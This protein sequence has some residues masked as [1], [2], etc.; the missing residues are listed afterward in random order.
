MAQSIYITSTE[1]LSGKS[2][3]VLGVLDAL[4]RT[5]PRVGVF[6]A[7]AR[8]AVERDYVLEMLLDHIGV[9]LEYEE[10]VGVTY[11]EV[12][13]DPD[14]ALSKIVER[15]KAVEAKCDAV[16]IVGSD[17]TDVGSTS[18]LGYNARIAANPAHYVD[19]VFGE[20]EAGGTAMLYISDVSFQMLGFRTDV[21]TRPL[22][23]YTWDIM[24]KL[25]AVV[26]SMAVVLTGASII[27]RR[28]NGKDPDH[29][30]PPWERE[31]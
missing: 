16:V 8:S 27:T 4:S 30:T 19:H 10:S 26:G 14:A 11:D 6:R 15:F 25:P 21:T 18:E 17:F 29:D 24:S 22:P 23:A 20:Q 31:S 28:R 3:V 13:R 9:E 5:T 12:R 1:G 2:T 7:I